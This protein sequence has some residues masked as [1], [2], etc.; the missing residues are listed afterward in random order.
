MERE[1]LQ[2]AAIPYQTVTVNDHHHASYYPGAKPITPAPRPPESGRL[3]GAQASGSEGIDKRL[4]VLSTAIVAGM[5]V[6]DLC[7]LELAYA[8]PFGS[9]K[10]V[11]NLAGLPPAT[12]AT[13]W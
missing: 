12:A 7:H 8:P 13:A 5:S 4:D 11:I 2:A 9:A 6:E 10:D 3:L 1:R